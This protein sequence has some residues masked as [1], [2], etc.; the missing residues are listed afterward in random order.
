MA[1]EKSYVV[2]LD[3]GGSKIFA[4]V[5]DQEGKLYS[6]AKEQTLAIEGFEVSF[7]QIVKCINAA[8]S[9]AGLTRDDIQAIGVGTP[10][11]L[12]LTNGIVI[13][14]PNLKW[15]NVPIRDT[16]QKEFNKP[17]KIDNDVNTGV[18]GEFA[19][20]A[21]RDAKHVLGFFIGTGL[22]GGV[23]I[24]GKLLH[25]F[26]QNAGELGHVIINPKGPFCECGGRGHL[27][28]YASKTGI[29][30]KI[31]RAIAK[32]K[33]TSIK[34]KMESTT[35]PLKSSWLAKA[36]KKGDRVVIKAID[37]SAR[38]MGYAVAS[39]LNVFNPEVVIL[40]GGIVESFGQSYIDK[41]I[42]VTRQNVFPIAFQ[43]VKIVAAELGDN[44]V[45]LGA[46][47]LAFEALQEA[48]KNK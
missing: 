20:G 15:K 3:I 11:P 38:Y 18:F 31:R 2:G 32:G 43:N 29:E 30:K 37:R 21:A 46:S 40:G 47:V 1:H 9:N 41:V 13:D 14:T 10:G 27:E 5:I 22:G 45:I 7:Q 28:V 33:E 19:F 8:I 48:E 12:D 36:Y 6:T 42:E 35:G 16:I 23:I 4:G 17:V 26:N 39:F 24:D 25:G 34:S 44:S